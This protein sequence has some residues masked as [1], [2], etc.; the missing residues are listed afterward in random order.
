VSS[1]L[2][3]IADE[4]LD[5]CVVPALKKVAQSW[6]ALLRHRNAQAAQAI[7]NKRLHEASDF[8]EE[9]QNF[10]NGQ[11]LDEVDEVAV[12]MAFA[13]SSLLPSTLNLQMLS[14]PCGKTEC[15]TAW[16]E[17][18]ATCPEAERASKSRSG[19]L[20]HERNPERCCPTAS[21]RQIGAVAVVQAVQMS[22]TGSS[23]LGS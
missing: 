2:N 22:H 9:L 5:R 19:D 10:H 14:S 1:V 16:G 6:G 12:A 18:R 3:Y 15:H 20:Q 11:Y 7:N 4:P 8:S 17:I 13:L 23:C 21:P